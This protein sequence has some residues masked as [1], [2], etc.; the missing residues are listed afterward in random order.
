L[1]T[2]YNAIY[3]NTN[4]IQIT[5]GGI[6]LNDIIVQIGVFR[7]GCDAGLGIY[8]AGDFAGHL[9]KS[10]DYGNNWTDL[11]LVSVGAFTSLIIS[12]SR[13]LFTYAATFSIGYTDD[14]GASHTWVNTGVD[15][16]ICLAKIE[17][18]ILLAG[19][20]NGHIYRSI[21]NGNSWS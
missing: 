14:E 8:Y 2:F 1:N 5:D 15:V 9:W 3:Y 11:G 17:G 12:G 21:D 10:I 13:L 19:T 6:L 4:L 18:N 7:T 20:S 16:P